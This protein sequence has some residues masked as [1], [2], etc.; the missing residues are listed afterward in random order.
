MNDLFII[1][2]SLVP[3]KHKLTNIIC[4]MSKMFLRQTTVISSVFFYLYLCA[5]IEFG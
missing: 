2:P 3:V 1:L 4:E 5:I